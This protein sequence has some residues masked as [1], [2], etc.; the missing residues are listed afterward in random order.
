MLM[1]VNGEKMLTAFTE[2]FAGTALLAILNG[3]SA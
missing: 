3:F 1:A 2:I